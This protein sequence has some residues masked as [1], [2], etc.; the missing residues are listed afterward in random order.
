MPEHMQQNAC[1]MRFSDLNTHT[2]SSQV[3]DFCNTSLIP[4]GPFGQPYLGK[5]TAA[6]RAALAVP[7]S[8]CNICLRPSKAGLPVFGMFKVC[9][10]VDVCNCTQGLCGHRQSLH[11]KLTRFFF[12]V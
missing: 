8:V 4:R 2:H 10:E 3:N 6:T 5:A 1:I 7:T 12:S 11:S 9:M